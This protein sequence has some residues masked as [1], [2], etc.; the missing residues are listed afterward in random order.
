MSMAVS[1]QSN[2]EV[3]GWASTD[4]VVL[5][6]EKARDGHRRSFEELISLFQQ[7]IFRMIFNRTRS[8]LDAEDLTQ[9]VFL[10]AFKNIHKLENGN[11]FR[12]WLFGIAINCVRDFHRKRRF[13]SFFEGSREDIGKEQDNRV[14]SDVPLDR[15]INK[16]FWMHIK[17]MSNRF[18]RLE[19]EV[20]FL[21]YMDHLSIK[22]ISQA[23][24]KNESTIK[25]H[26]YRSLKKFRE[27]KALIGMLQ[28]AMQ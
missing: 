18:S 19:G 4:D 1:D 27:D 26:L 2:V 8:R 28:G 3:P 17:A 25:T 5:I 20:F 23:L 13:F 24:N 22:E 12:S 7:E 6:V 10:R 14:S 9:E 21:R 15:L 11:R 16:E